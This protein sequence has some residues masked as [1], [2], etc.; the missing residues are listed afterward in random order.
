[1]IF[2]TCYTAS[3]VL[4]IFLLS[5]TFLLPAQPIPL[6][7]CTIGQGVISLNP[8]GGNY[9]EGTLVSLTPVPDPGWKFDNWTGASSGTSN[10][11]SVR[12]EKKRIACVGNSITEGA[13]LQ[14][15]PQES[16]PG[17]LQSL[18]GSGYEVLNFGYSG[19]TVSNNSPLP[20]MS[21]QVYSDALASQADIV[22]IMLGT[23]DTFEWLNKKDDFPN[24]LAT[25]AQ[26]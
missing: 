26:S 19:A 7:T 21:Q 3:F 13:L 1:M 4:L 5:V 12:V 8:T 16:Y 11:L 14:N 25:L 10:P 24:A 17:Q 15:P 18:L 22:T 2:K 6:S 23:N 20:Y 9:A